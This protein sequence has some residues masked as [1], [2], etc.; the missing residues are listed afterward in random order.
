ME[1]WMHML[2]FQH[3]ANPNLKQEDNIEESILAARI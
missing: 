1:L 3:V 2:A